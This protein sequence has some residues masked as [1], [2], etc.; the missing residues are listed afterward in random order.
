MA[1]VSVH[2]QVQGMKLRE[3]SK[4]IGCSQKEALGILVSLWLWGI[5]N[6]TKDGELKSSNKNDIKDALSIGLSG[7]LSPDKVVD[8]L[9]E[10][11]WIDCFDGKYILHDWDIWQEQWYKAIERRNYDTRRKREERKKKSNACPQD[12]PSENPVQPSPSPSPI[13]EEEEERAREG[14]IFKFFNKNIGMITPFQSE[15][16]SQYLADGL[17][18]EMIIAVL[19]DSVGK[20]DCWSWIRT[21][22]NNSTTQNIKTLEQYEAKKVERQNAKSRDGPNGKA[23]TRNSGSQ[24]EMLQRV[25]QKLKEAKPP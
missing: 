24:T 12:S 8:C 20:D 10:C 1:W 22:L 9:I 21:V 6:A 7:G 11:H 13:E 5:N 17:E 4:K 14:K 19:Q 18:P 2:E 25:K 16:I 3:L 23:N 15:T